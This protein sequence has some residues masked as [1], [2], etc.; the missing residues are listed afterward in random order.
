M[1]SSG[2]GLQENRFKSRAL[3]FTSQKNYKRS[4]GTNS[5]KP[6]QVTAV[7]GKKKEKK[8]TCW[9]ML[10]VIIPQISNQQLW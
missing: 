6:L 1:V 2:V 4:E 10:Q 7:Q 3:R 9:I 8:K 5:D